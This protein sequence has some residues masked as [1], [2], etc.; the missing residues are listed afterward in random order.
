MTGTQDSSGKYHCGTLAYTKMGLFALF[1]WLL[2]GDFVYNLMETVVPTVLPLKLKALGASNT[3]MSVIMTVL[4]SVLGMTVCPWVSFRS[5]RY[6]SH[7]GRRIPFILFTLPFLL[8][9]LPC[10]RHS[11]VRRKP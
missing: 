4:P 1:G 2:W 3:L 8:N 6:R 9:G 11:L 10:W 7:W 5:D